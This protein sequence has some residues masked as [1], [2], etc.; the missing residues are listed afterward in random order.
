[1]AEERKKFESVFPTIVDEV[2]QYSKNA[3]MPQSAVDWYKNVRYIYFFFAF[4][5]GKLTVCRT[6][7][8]ILWEE[9]IIAV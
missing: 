5:I 2:V 1:M 8:I 3:G 6:S 7:Y 9:N 4:L